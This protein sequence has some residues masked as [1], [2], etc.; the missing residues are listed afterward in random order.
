M[1][2]DTAD[3]SSARRLPLAGGIV[4]V[5]LSVALAGCGKQGPPQP[6]FRSI[7]ATTKDLAARQQG[8][9]I[10]LSFG[11]PQATASGTA[12]GGIAAA[13]LWEVTRPA[14]GDRIEPVDARL[15]SSLAKQRLKLEGPDLASA[16]AGDRLTIALPLPTAPAG[17]PLPA[18]YFAVRTLGKDGDSSEYSNIVSLLPKA[19]PPAPE[20]VVVTARANGVLVEWS[21]V[22]AAT[23]GYN[24]YRRDAA[25]R[26]S[27]Q[28]VYQAAATERSWLDATAQ[29]GQSYIY[30]VTS[31]VQ[32]EPI[33][34]S[35]VTSER[36]V[37]YQDRFAPDSPKELVAL[38]EPKQVRLVWRASDAADVAGYHVYRRT[39]DQGAFQKITPQPQPTPELI[40]GDVTTGRSYTY[41]IVAIDQAG[42]ESEPST[43][44]RAVIP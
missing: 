29:F 6:P 11:Y 19:P 14:A 32:R 41:R 39:G 4:L 33:L 16:T 34:E 43:E 15:F 25:S 7:P 2:F 42:N 24:V 13:E 5:L 40:D 23:A 10:L 28:P 21:A 31:V 8:G 35:P 26:I 9:Q 38:A 17:T 36:E 44:A 12:L 27:G 37:R 3:R 22:E 30:A 18:S 20:R 1:S